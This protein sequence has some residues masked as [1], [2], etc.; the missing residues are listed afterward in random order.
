M[1]KRRIFVYILFLLV[2]VI[3]VIVRQKEVTSRRNQEI[4]STY[5]EWKKHGK[6]VSIKEVQKE[7]V[8]TFTKLTI[9]PSSPK[10]YE[11]YVP[12]SIQKKLLPNQDV[13]LIDNQENA[14]GRVVF[15]SEDMDLRTGMFNIKIV[16]NE[17][18]NYV[19]ER[20]VVY[21][22]TGVIRGSIC[23]PNDIIKTE[24][25]DNQFLWVVE[26]NRARKKIIIVQKR[27]GYGS[28]ISQGLNVGD[29][30]V[31]NGFSNLSEGDDLHLVKAPSF[32]G[33]LR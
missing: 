2:I 31:V 10:E 9:V 29:K 14:I 15:V 27:N 28:I 30:I 17:T 22:N 5:S 25:D 6:P 16:L 7:D 3:G 18:V 33:E 21:I 24:K 32:E 20:F 4:Q 23:V 26:Q 8:R 13:F 11:S 19:H 12:K 1:N